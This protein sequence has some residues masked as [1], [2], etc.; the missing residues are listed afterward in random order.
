VD[1]IRHGQPELIELLRT[2]GITTDD[3]ERYLED[4]R[5]YLDEINQE[6]TRD[7]T[8]ISAEYVELLEKLARAK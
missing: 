7:D 8:M 2:L 1:R 5:D 6:D 3:L 4:E